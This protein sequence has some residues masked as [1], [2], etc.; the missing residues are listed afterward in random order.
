MPTA[1]PHATAATCP[2]T[3][4][5]SRCLPGSHH[6]RRIKATIAVAVLVAIGVVGLPA[7]SGVRLLAAPSLA[8]EVAS[9]GEGVFEASPA[10]LA[11][12]LSGGG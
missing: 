3:P 11:A 6:P 2:P 8:A 4:G 7:R 10:A 1:S 5:L 12:E 9:K